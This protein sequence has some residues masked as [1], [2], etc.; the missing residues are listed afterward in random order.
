MSR[1]LVN[2]ETTSR[3]LDIHVIGVLGQKENLK[4]Y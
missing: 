2:C 1:V 3:G 4:N